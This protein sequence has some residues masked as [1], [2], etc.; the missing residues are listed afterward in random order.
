MKKIVVGIITCIL[1]INTVSANT[2]DV[3]TFSKCVDG[4]TIEVIQN[5][6]KKK[7][8]L[9]AVDTPET[10]HPKKG[11]EPFGKE[12]STFT[13]THVKNAKTLELEYDDGSDKTDK[14][15]RLLA[16]VF[17]DGYNLNDLLIQEGL[18][19]VA[20]LYGDYK[21]TSLLKDHQAVSQSKKLNIWSDKTPEEK[22]NLDWKFFLLIVV[23][24]IL[25]FLFE[26]PLRKW[27]RNTNKLKRTIKK[28]EKEVNRWKS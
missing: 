28:A 23:V 11:E 15:G 5:G 25:L 14:Y 22:P 12:A 16:W 20:Y 21:Y 10:K 27:K 3:V 19:E 8:R 7:V 9:L 2:K 4:D 6:E 24:T 18:A 17:V 26:K 13:C 1:F